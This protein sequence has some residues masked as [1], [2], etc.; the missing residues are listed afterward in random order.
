LNNHFLKQVKAIKPFLV[1]DHPT[2]R[3]ADLAKMPETQLVTLVPRHTWQRLG[4]YINQYEAINLASR[5]GVQL[6]ALEWEWVPNPEAVRWWRRNVTGE[7]SLFAMVLG[8]TRGELVE[9]Y[10]LVEVDEDSVNWAEVIPEEA[11]NAMPEQARLA[12]RAQGQPEQTVLR[13]LYREYFRR[14]GMLTL[15]VP[16]QV[17]LRRG[18]VREVERFR[19]ALQRLIERSNAA[20]L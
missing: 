14:R 18:T 16:G 15:D 6:G 2:Y 17:A 11:S 13:S 1:N 7:A 12:A 4:E 10:G 20:V 9:L 5:F 19:D 3:F 8:V